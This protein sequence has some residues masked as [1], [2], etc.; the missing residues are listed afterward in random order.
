MDYF[1]KQNWNR[2][3]RWWFKPVILA[4]RRQRS[5]RWKFEAR[6]IVHK[7]LSQTNKQTSKQTTTTKKTITK[8]GY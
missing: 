6:Q 5:G 1:A 7:T 2:T 4:T 8:Q 3:G